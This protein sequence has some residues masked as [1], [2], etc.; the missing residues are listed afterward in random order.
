MKVLI[1]EDDWAVRSALSHFFSRRGYQVMEADSSESALE[2][3]AGEE[4][5]AAILDIVLPERSQDRADFDQDVGVT[6]ARALRARNPQLGIIFLS[7]YMDRASEVAALYLDGQG[8]VIYL[9]KGSKPQELVDAIRTVSDKRAALR[10]ET[11]SHVSRQSALD[12]ALATLTESE[13]VAINL[14]LECI[15]T[16][17]EP[18]LK[19]FASVGSCR[20]RRHAA[21]QLPISEHTVNSHVEQIYQKLHLR[22]APDGLSQTMLLAKIHLLYELGQLKND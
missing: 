8:P 22:E 6:I 21:T 15:D 11:D 1:V 10:I 14:A 2:V 3:V 12:K 17:S 13:A 19:V 4:P 18:E 5:D 9:P 20:S 16:L 7:A